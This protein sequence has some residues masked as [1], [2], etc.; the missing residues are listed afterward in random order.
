M[1][2]IVSNTV[3]LIMQRLQ[4]KH[5]GWVDFEEFHFVSMVYLN[6]IVEFCWFYKRVQF[7]SDKWYE[8]CS[9]SYIIIM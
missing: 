6:N 7:K 2:A 5:I 9:V 8:Q 4:F 3:I 1:T